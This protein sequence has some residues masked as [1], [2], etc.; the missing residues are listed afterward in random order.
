VHVVWGLT[1]TLWEHR[2]FEIV[3]GGPV[4]WDLAHAP[5]NVASAY[6]GTWHSSVERVT[7]PRGVG[8]GAAIGAILGG[9][10]AIALNRATW[11]EWIA[12]GGRRATVLALGTSA[13][14]RDARIR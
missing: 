1:L 9:A 13:P 11:H 4:D 14:R 8:V 6:P 10:G 12:P 5:T 3:W 2:D 7:A